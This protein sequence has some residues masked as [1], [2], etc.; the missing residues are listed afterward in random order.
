MFQTFAALAIVISMI[1]A[2]RFILQRVGGG[3]TAAAHV[4]PL[5]EVLARTTIA[6]KTQVMFLKINQ[7][8]VAVCQSPAGMHPLTTFDQPDDMAW[9][10]SQIESAK[11]MSISQGFRQLVH[12]FD[13]DYA[14]ESETSPTG[15]DTG[16]QYIDR[17]RD[18]MSSLLSRLRTLS[19]GKGN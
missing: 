18:S 14:A 19:R 17:T 9:I 2:L 4:A 13:R 8:I 15:P 6:P 1:F 16:E 12:R 3:A 5:V 11:P 10:L 7:R